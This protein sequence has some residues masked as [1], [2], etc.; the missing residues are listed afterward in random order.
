MCVCLQGLCGEILAG[1]IPSGLPG[2]QWEVRGDDG[3]LRSRLT[4]WETAAW[5]KCLPHCHE[6]GLLTHY[7]VFGNVSFPLDFSTFM[8]LTQR[9]LQN[10]SAFDRYWTTLC[11]LLKDARQVA[12]P[13]VADI[14]QIFHWWWELTMRAKKREEYSARR[15]LSKYFFLWNFFVEQ[16]VFLCILLYNFVNT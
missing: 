4:P 16:N 9:L 5:E 3:M 12:E 6:V 1:K 15:H 2:A 14:C 10:W 8:V 13:G 7:S 11:E